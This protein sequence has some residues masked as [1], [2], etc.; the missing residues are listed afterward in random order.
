[1]HQYL[2]HDEGELALGKSSNEIELIK[3]NDQKKYNSYHSLFL[4]Y[5]HCI[6]NYTKGKMES[7][8]RCQKSIK[9]KHRYRELTFVV[10]NY[11]E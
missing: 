10:N 5:Y 9:M 7:D 2:Q 11:E 1:M 8:S 6:V 4:R 3:I